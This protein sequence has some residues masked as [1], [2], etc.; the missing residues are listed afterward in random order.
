MGDKGTSWLPNE[1]FTVNFTMRLALL[2]FALAGVL[3]LR[4]G[5]SAPT[6]TT[7]EEVTGSN[8]A[9]STVQLTPADIAAAASRVLDALRANSETEEEASADVGGSFDQV[10][11]DLAAS[12]GGSDASDDQ[13]RATIARISVER[14]LA[15]FGRNRNEAN[16]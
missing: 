3:N 6:G 9:N 13:I 11:A 2:L 16:T 7:E 10:I 5:V 12:L 4:D 1:I 15:E 8:P 14:H